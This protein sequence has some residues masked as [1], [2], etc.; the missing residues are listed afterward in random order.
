MN[1]F[2]EN[3]AIS[4]FVLG[5]ILIIIGLLTI[6]WA[7]LEFGMKLFVTGVTFVVAGVLCSFGVGG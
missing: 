7:T 6:T 1:K 2:L 5:G 4:F 3:C